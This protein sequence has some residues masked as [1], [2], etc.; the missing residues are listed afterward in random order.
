MTELLSFKGRIARLPYLGYNLANMAFVLVSALISAMFLAAGTAG[1]VLG[2][3]LMLSAIAIAIWF[4]LAVTA[5]R[6]RDMGRSPLHAIWIYAAG[7]LSS[8]F[9]KVPG[10]EAAQL[11]TA[12]VT[13]GGSLW[14]LFAPGTP[15]R[16]T[17]AA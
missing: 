10:A 5:K 2:A 16:E 15:D 7:T 1:A 4:G 14:L 13:L 12:L 6:L 11:L 8:I 17:A 9:E 3:A